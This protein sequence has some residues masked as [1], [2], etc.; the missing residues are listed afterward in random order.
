MRVVCA[1]NTGL[2][3]VMQHMSKS[4]GGSINTDSYTKNTST[5][6]SISKVHNYFPGQKLKESLGFIYGPWET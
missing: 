5:T 4:S 2:K 6:V 3:A 1:R